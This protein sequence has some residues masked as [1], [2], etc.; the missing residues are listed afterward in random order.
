MRGCLRP[1]ARRMRAPP[2]GPGGVLP[3]CTR[4]GLRTVSAKCPGLRSSTPAGAGVRCA[5]LARACRWGGCVPPDRR[6]HPRAGHAVCCACR[7]GHR[8]RRQGSAGA[9][10]QGWSRGSWWRVGLAVRRCPIAAGGEPWRIVHL[11]SFVASGPASQWGW[12]GEAAV[13]WFRVSA[14]G[15]LPVRV[16]VATAIRSVQTMLH[17]LLHAA[18]GEPGSRIRQ[19]HPHD[20]AGHTRLNSEESSTYSANVAQSWS[21]AV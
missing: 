21:G 15:G 1:C 4:S 16:A 9:G 20:R 5:A 13:L 19:Q 2:A 10:S 12:N 14:T 8:P 18:R 3:R 11:E 17:H 6:L 7:A